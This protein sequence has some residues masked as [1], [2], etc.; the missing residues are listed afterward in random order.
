MDTEALKAL[1]EARL[2]IEFLRVLVPMVAEAVTLASEG[3]IVRQ[4]LRS[5]TSDVLFENSHAAW[6]G[7]QKIT[8]F[9][10]VFPDQLDNVKEGDRRRTLREFGE[11]RGLPD[12][13][14]NAW[15]DLCAIHD[16]DTVTKQDT[17]YLQQRQQEEQRLKRYLISPSAYG[18]ELKRR[19]PVSSESP[20]LPAA[21]ALGAA[22]LL[23]FR[24][25]G[26][27]WV[28]REGLTTVNGRITLADRVIAAWSKDPE[29]QDRALKKA[30]SHGSWSRDLFLAEL[31]TIYN[32]HSV[33][34]ATASRA[35]A[36]PF[37]G[38]YNTRGV[39]GIADLMRYA[40]RTV[41][42]KEA[43]SASEGDRA[44]SLAGLAK[45]LDER[46]LAALKIVAGRVPP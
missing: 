30:M 41:M 29:Y 46:A 17:D 43:K 38:Q 14:I 23:G 28:N 27:M 31:C 32:E 2:L 20:R 10:G 4:G 37:Y 8:H 39:S 36:R 19:R 42:K 24:F 5:A 34:M 11:E 13:G 22:G 3:Y 33:Q 7:Q 45:I 35:R 40:T 6:M 16:L 25:Y 12:G 18:R 26:D 21:S 9:E 1:S 44:Q 15:C